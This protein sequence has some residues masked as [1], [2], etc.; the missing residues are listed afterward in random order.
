ME[1]KNISQQSALLIAHRKYRLNEYWN[2]VI[3]FYNYTVDKPNHFLPTTRRHDVTQ[4][5]VTI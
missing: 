4:Y 1:M 3:A 5:Y 2:A